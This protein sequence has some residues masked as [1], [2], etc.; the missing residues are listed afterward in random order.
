MVAGSIVAGGLGWGWPG[1]LSLAVVRQSPEAPGAAM[2]IAAT[3]LFAG[4]V[5]GPIAAGGLV[6]ETSF[7]ALWVACGVLSLLAALV[8]AGARRLILLDVNAAGRA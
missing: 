7:D 5:L 2:G 1:L 3:G 6:E 4:A 8:V